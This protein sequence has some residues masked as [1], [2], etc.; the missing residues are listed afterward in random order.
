MALTLRFVVERVAYGLV[1][2]FLLSLVIFFCTQ[3]LP[4]D[5][6]VTML[7]EQATDDALANLRARLGLD[8]PP[9][10]QYLFWLGGLVTGDPGV[11]HTL[12]QPITAILGPRFWNSLALTLMTVAVAAAI[13]IPLGVIAAIR[14]GRGADGAILTFSYL[15]I[16]VPDFVLGPL[17]IVAFA[18]PPIALFPSSG[19]VPFAESPLGWL[20]HMVLPVAALTAILTAHLVRQTRSGILQVL[21]SDY[22]R[23][24]RLKGMP[25]RV[26]LWRHCLRNGLTTTI[27]VLALDLGFLMGSIV[28]IEEVFAYPGLGRLAVYAV[29]NRDI[30]LIQA[31]TLVIAAVYVAA[32]ILADFAHAALNPRVRQQ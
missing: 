23:T 5:A 12:G 15:G 27:T 9:H 31:T 20:H 16:S 7:G 30:P 14:Q 8:R 24:A 28:I 21:R 22:I 1:T 10:E 13:A 32:N 26:V 18:S 4:G 11:S 6:A 17:L 3:V 2:L 25:E 19:H 29:G